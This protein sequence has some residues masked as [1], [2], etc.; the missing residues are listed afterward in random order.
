[1]SDVTVRRG[2]GD[3]VAYVLD[4]G[5]RTVSDSI[6]TY[7]PAPAI[8]AQ[9]SYEK[10]VQFI[11]QQPYLL[12]VAEDEDDRLGFAILLDSFPDEVTAL[13]QGF[14]AYMAVEPRARRKGI[15]RALLTAAE[16]AARVRGLPHVALMVTEDNAAA[17]ELY[18]QAGYVTERRLLCKAL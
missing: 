8:L 3:D 1:V 10:F 16:D 17:R 14:I 15:A 12:F 6:S 2:S 18:A 9:A 4:L 13:P 11:E 7:R 5:S